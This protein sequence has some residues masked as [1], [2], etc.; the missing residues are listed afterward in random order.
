MTL[1][2]A[3]AL[4]TMIALGIPL[5]GRHFHNAWKIGCRSFSLLFPMTLKA[6]SMPFYHLSNTIKVYQGH[7]KEH[8]TNIMFCIHKQWSCHYTLFNG[9]E[10]HTLLWFVPK[11]ALNETK[12]WS[13]KFS[14]ISNC[15]GV[16]IPN[17]N[18]MSYW[19]NRFKS[20]KACWT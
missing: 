2:S 10:R 14:I 13:P 16:W 15:H 12:L 11:V 8:V 1:I 19:F 18:G 3:C 5:I 20:K 9:K 6:T 4:S 7:C 17:V